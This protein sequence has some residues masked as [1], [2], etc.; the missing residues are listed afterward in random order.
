[1]KLI[2]RID[3]VSSPALFTFWSLIHIIVAIVIWIVVKIIFKDIS[4]T[5]LFIILFLAHICYETKDQIISRNCRRKELKGEITKNLL[6]EGCIN[7]LENS[8]GDQFCFTTGLVIALLLSKVVDCYNWKF[9]IPII[10]IVIAMMI[11]SPMMKW[12]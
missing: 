12:G 3:L 1:M 11:V 6:E 9:C 7:S 5:T 8:I 4:D 10:I 2:G